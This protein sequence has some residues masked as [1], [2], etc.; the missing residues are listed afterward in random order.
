[1]EPIIANIVARNGNFSLMKLPSDIARRLYVLPRDIVYLR[2]FMP[3]RLMDV[4]AIGMFEEYA[5]RRGKIPAIIL[6]NALKPRN[7]MHVII[8]VIRRLGRIKEYKAYTRTTFNEYLRHNNI[9]LGKLYS[10]RITIDPLMPLIPTPCEYSSIDYIFIPQA[11]PRGNRLYV[12]KGSPIIKG[13]AVDYPP[14]RCYGLVPT[15][16]SRYQEAIIYY[17]AF[18]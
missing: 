18:H 12:V 2:F 7:G 8:R 6:S 15:S 5:N 1:M 11:L 17:L 9:D 16:F 10:I 13:D 4:R 3:D 14:N